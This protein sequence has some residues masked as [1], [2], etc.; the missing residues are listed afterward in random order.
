MPEHLLFKGVGGG[1]SGGECPRIVSGG[2]AEFPQKNAAAFRFEDRGNDKARG[3]SCFQEPIAQARKIA[4]EQRLDDGDDVRVFG[5]LP[6]FAKGFIEGGFG[7][8]F[9]RECVN[10][11]IVFRRRGERLFDELELRKGVERGEGGEGFGALP[12]SVGVEA[13]SGVGAEFGAAAQ[14]FFTA[15]DFVRKRCESDFDFEAVMATVGE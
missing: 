3:V 12:G 13:N 1:D 8:V 4:D 6:R 15:I 10:G 5:H 9:R 7:G 2:A 14:D 11:G